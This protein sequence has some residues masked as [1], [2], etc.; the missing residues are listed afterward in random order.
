MTI[1]KYLTKQSIKEEAIH[2]LKLF[3]SYLWQMEEVGI[4]TDWKT[5]DKRIMGIIEE[6]FDIQYRE[7]ADKDDVWFSDKTETKATSQKPKS[8]TSQKYINPANNKE[9][10]YQRAKK[11]GLV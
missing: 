5:F 10:S 1:P 2:R 4:L 6:E 9:V 7:P 3:R 11:L 8:K